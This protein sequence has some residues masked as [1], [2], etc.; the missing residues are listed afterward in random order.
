M[1]VLVDG[2]T[3]NLD[4]PLPH[5]TNDM[6]DDAERIADSLTI[7]D[8]EVGRGRT[9]RD[10]IALLSSASNAS[11]LPNKAL[12][13]KL[14]TD[15]PEFAVYTPLTPDGIE[16]CRWYFTNRFNDGGGSGA[17]RMIG[18]TL[19]GLYPGVPISKVAS[20]KS[21]GTT[22][23]AAVVTLNSAS[24]TTIGSWSTPATVNTVTDVS[25]STTIGDQ[26]I[27]TVSG[28]QRIVLRGL[29][30]NLNGGIANVKV[31][32]DAGFTTEIPESNYDTPAD[33]LVNFWAASEGL[34]HFPIASGLNAGATYYVVV[35][36]DASNTDGTR[37]RVYQAGIL[38]YDSIAYNSTGIHG[39]VDDA[40][41]PGSSGQ[42]NSR[43]YNPGTTAVYQLTNCTKIDW[44]YVSTATGSIVKLKVFNSGGTLVASV[45]VDTY[46][47]GSTS[48]KYSVIRGLPKGTYYL[49][50][51]N[52]KTRNASGTGYR[53]YDFGAIS[54]DETTAG[55]LGT[56]EF[57][58]FDVPLIDQDPNNGT[59][60]MFIG[61]GNLEL[62]LRVRRAVDPVPTGGNGFVGGIHGLETAPTLTVYDGNGDAVDFAGA[63][64]YAEFVSS[65][66][67]FNFSTSLKFPL[68]TSTNFMDVD[69]KYHLSRAGYAV[70]T[71]K[72][73]TAEVLIHLDYS[74]ML[75]TPNTAA[76]NQGL[77]VGGGFKYIAADKN[78]TLTSFNDTGTFIAAPQNAVAFVN[79]KYA[80]TCHYTLI[81]MP[82]DMKVSPYVQG[83]TWSLAQD[84]PDRT[85]KFYT[86]AFS[87]DKSNGVT[88]PAGKVWTHAKLY[89]VHPG[90][91][92][93]EV[94]LF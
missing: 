9:Q 58:N 32:T 36:V 87:G 30:A 38:G 16:W 21:S 35:T 90:N 47:A 76:N 64:Q 44:R 84:R 15:Y 19:A 4:L 65:S 18:C 8:A 67:S 28:A 22:A 59:E 91:H 73:T 11:A 5:P 71:K 86:E 51:T 31:Y 48:K 3:A 14:R 70:Y 62:A 41:L 81:D 20:N 50:V 42:F 61:A 63:A 26:K 53:Y 79:S 37:N 45:N 27:Y 55:V 43:S 13:K 75:N 10:I 78:Y 92:M 17:T 24:A 57:D 94:G 89:R 83:S 68:A 93:T 82:D 33:R 6:Y 54:Y 77:S 7:L 69:Y 88:V 12:L 39:V 49:H 72:T 80:V 23:T 85:M 2:R 74:L 40:E 60:Y 25:Y 56:D 46:S 66:F 52:G 34:M 29:N 1:T